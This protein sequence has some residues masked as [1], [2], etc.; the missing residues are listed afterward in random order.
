MEEREEGDVCGGT[1]MSLLHGKGGGGMCVGEGVI[2]MSPC[3]KILREKRERG[4]MCVGLITLMCL[5][6]GKG[7]GG[8]CVG[9]GVI[10]MS[11]LHGKGEERERVCVWGYTTAYSVYHRNNRYLYYT[12]CSKWE[13]RIKTHVH[14]HTA[15]AHS[16]T[17]KF[18][19]FLRAT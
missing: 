17:V 3:M 9:E 1:L 18:S 14:T 12:V 8:M 15:L 2:L 6:H 16:R 10:L 5:L 11:L 19:F 13:L 4:G 7:G